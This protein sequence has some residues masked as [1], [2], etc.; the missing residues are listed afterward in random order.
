MTQKREWPNAA[1]EARDRSAEEAAHIVIN[2][3]P[4]I[5]GSDLMGEAEK[6]K[7]VGR[8]LN[9]AQ[10]ILRLLENL[11]APTRVK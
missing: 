4:L 2:L 5:E 9:S 6:M 10:K 3:E 1:K 7:R 11:G 8:S